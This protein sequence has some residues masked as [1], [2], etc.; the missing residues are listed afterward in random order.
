MPFSTL[1]PVF[2][3][4]VFHGAAG[5][6]GWLNSI[7]GLGALG[8]AIYLASRPAGG[9]QSQLISWAT[10]GFC[11]ATLGF[12]LSPQLNVALVFTLLGG[13]GMMLFIAG[14]NTFVQTN[15]ADY[16]R[17]RVLSY[18]MMAFQGVQ[19]LGSLLVGWLARHLGAPHTVQLQAVA[20]LLVVGVFWRGSQKKPSSLPALSLGR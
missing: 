4:D 6:F 20:G 1:L 18:Y 16:M 7:A 15:V 2:A 5:T 8:G 17:G 11:A 10:L 12:A 3:R 13:T 14:I 9:R 19:P